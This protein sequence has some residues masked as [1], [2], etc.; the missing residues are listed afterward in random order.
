M[1]VVRP[2]RAIALVG[3]FGALLNFGALKKRLAM[4]LH[5]YQS[6]ILYKLMSSLIV[7]KSGED[8]CINLSAIGWGTTCQPFIATKINQQSTVDQTKQSETIQIFYTIGSLLDLYK[9]EGDRSRDTKAKKPCYISVLRIK[10]TTSRIVQL[11]NKR[12]VNKIV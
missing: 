10:K 1:V 9:I 5:L 12:K 6:S 11:Y 7:Q 4:L 8:N 2:A 3:H